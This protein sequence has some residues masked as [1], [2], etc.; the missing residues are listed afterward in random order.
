MI[1]PVEAEIT[2]K[3]DKCGELFNSPDDVR[4]HNPKAHGDPVP[5]AESG[6]KDDADRGL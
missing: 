2:Y 4:A 1:E 3:C 6:L 5:K